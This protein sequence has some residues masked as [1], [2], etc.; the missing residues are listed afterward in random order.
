[1]IS[2]ISHRCD[3]P[4]ISRSFEKVSDILD[5]VYTDRSPHYGTVTQTTSLRGSCSDHITMLY[6]KSYG[7]Q[8]LTMHGVIESPNIRLITSEADHVIIRM[9]RR[10][11]SCFTMHF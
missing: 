6:Q 3:V 11:E 8:H 10:K 5:I 2:Y 7:K 9:F 1:M 4:Y